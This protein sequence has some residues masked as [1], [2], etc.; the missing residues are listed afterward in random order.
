MNKTLRWKKTI[1]ILA[2]ILGGLRFIAGISS[3]SQ[4]QTLKQEIDSS[5]SFLSS[6]FIEDARS[7]I[8]HCESMLPVELIVLGVI[9]ILG[10]V[11]LCTEKGLTHKEPRPVSRKIAVSILIGSLI[12]LGLEII[13]YISIPSSIKEYLS[14]A[15]II[16]SLGFV[17][18]LI[19]FCIAGIAS[20]K[21]NDELQ[22]STIISLNQTTPQNINTEN[23]LKPELTSLDVEIAELKKQ[24]EKRK[25]EKEV[26][27]L[28][29]E[30]QAEI[31]K[32]KKELTEL[33]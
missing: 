7:Y 5:T 23:K 22:N 19:G 3:Y 29:A 12:H 16:G 18:V 30:K 31:E 25:L 14:S 32:L 26:A 27:Q 2:I 8:S 6:S 24:I 20:Y 28:N 33:N 1:G 15:T 17:L 10:I 13:T 21:W 11:L 4:I 9:L